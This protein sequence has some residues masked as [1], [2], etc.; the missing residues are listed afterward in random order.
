MIT[1]GLYYGVKL[2]DNI[3]KLT[4]HIDLKKFPDMNGA[5]L[6][7]IGSLSGDGIAGVLLAILSAIVLILFAYIFVLT[8]WYLLVFFAAMLYWVYFRALRLVFKN[9]S[10]C[11]NDIKSSL[12]LGFIY[13]SLYTSWMFAIILSIHFLKL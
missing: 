1:I 3:G 2:K 6:P 11:K 5:S 8:S 12:K 4:E 13:S 10:Q 7:D 9:S